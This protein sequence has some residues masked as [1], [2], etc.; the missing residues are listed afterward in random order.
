MLKYISWF[1]LNLPWK[2]LFYLLNINYISCS[3]QF[4]SSFLNRLIL[5]KRKS[6]NLFVRRFTSIVPDPN[7][8][9]NTCCFIVREVYPIWNPPN[10]MSRVWIKR[11]NMMVIQ[12][13]IQFDKLLK[14]LTLRSLVCFKLN[15][16][17]ICISTKV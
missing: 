14:I 2:N 15:K 10:S 7:I 12:N 16:L 9:H 3:H 6:G 11:V 5:L 17:N 4:I 8:I 13:R 1:K